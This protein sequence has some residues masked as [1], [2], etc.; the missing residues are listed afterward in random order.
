M[1]D[2]KRKKTAGE[3]KLDLTFEQG[4]EKLESIIERIESGE[5]GLE[6]SLAE[7]ERGMAL[8]RHC[9]S[10][11]D[12]CDLRVEEITKE[13]VRDDEEGEVPAGDEE[14]SL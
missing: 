4:I 10:I 6:E 3:A 8:I 1:A 13:V 7:Y 12:R 9:S 11:L 5:V 2:S 14:T